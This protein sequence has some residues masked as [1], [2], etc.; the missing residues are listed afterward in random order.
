M[1]CEDV[2]CGVVSG[3][4]QMLRLQETKR[5]GKASLA[6]PCHIG[7]LPSHLLPSFGPYTRLLCLWFLCEMLDGILAAEN[8]CFPLD[9]SVLLTDAFPWL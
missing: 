7:G 3:R 4:V 5:A 9:R 6:F 8:R 1:R 2:W